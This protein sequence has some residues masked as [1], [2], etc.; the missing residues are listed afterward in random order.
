MSKVLRGKSVEDFKLGS[1][2]IL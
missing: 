1:R 2:W